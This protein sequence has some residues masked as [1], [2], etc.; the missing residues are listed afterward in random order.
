L[1][2]LAMK[3]EQIKNESL[4]KH[5]KVTVPAKSIDGEVEQEITKLSKTMKL[6]GFRPGK[7]PVSLIK[8]KYGGAVR[9]DVLEKKVKDS[10][11]KI[12][13]DNKLEP[14]ER[15][16][17]DDLKADE[18]KDLSFVVKMDVLPEIKHP[19]LKKVK[20]EK[21]TLKIDPKDAEVRLKEIVDA[22]PEFTKESKVKSVDGDQVE[23]D[24]TGFVDNKAFEGG[25]AKNHQLILGSNQ[26][27]PGFEEQLIGVKAGD[28]V[29]VKVAFPKDYHSK[30]L[31]GKDAIFETKVHKVFKS[32]KPKIDNDL[33]KK[34]G[35]EDLEAFKKD[36][37]S[38]LK[39]ANDGQIL[40]YMKLKLFDHLEKELKF[41]TPQKTLDAEYEAI[42]KQ[43][44][45]MQ[46]EEEDEAEAEAKTSKKKAAPKAKKEDSKDDEKTYKKIALRRV[47]IG[48]FMAD[49]ARKHSI[50]VEKR[51]LN[52]AITEQS[53]MFPGNQQFIIDFYTQNPQALEGLKGQILEEKA[54]RQILDNE[55]TTKE[56][57]FTPKALETFLKKELEDVKL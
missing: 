37:E 27:I 9:G 39:K 3:I 50:K 30:D 47:K 46:K 48:M 8:K 6:P 57:E 32:S 1:K 17:I 49:Y 56:K 41:D 33:A 45:A 53:K 26:F 44:S 29:K 25:S 42:K 13:E 51:D 12:V 52:N 24:F 22:N 11:T 40:E 35:F 20:L 2:Y 18:G 55:V 54:V 19:D 16:D 38:N 7:V 28:E 14:S 31:A 21:P 36:I 43:M 5:F 10:I 15:P 23:M 34:F 4:E